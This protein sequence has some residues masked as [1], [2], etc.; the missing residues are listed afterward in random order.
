MDDLKKQRHAAHNKGA[1][2]AWR[3]SD[4]QG[5]GVAEPGQRSDIHAHSTVE[6]R[7]SPANPA[8][9][10]GSGSVVG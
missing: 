8:A 7:G 1:H 3:T 4:H 6:Q 9:L 10:E 2:G 5:A